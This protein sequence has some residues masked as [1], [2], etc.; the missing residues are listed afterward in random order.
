MS[1]SRV[2]IYANAGIYIY[3]NERAALAQAQRILRVCVYEI[4]AQLNAQAHNKT[5]TAKMRASAL[6]ARSR[7]LASSCAYKRCQTN[8]VQGGGG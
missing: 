8:P 7:V 3:Y 6:Q 5:D 2:R 4:N 1:A